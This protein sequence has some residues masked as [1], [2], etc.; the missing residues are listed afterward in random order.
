[1]DANERTARFIAELDDIDRM[2]TTE[3]RA[4]CRKLVSQGGFL[5]VVAE[6]AIAVDA[7]VK[8]EEP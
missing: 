7:A 8:R 2:S 5:G 6:A 4:E 3:L 1:M